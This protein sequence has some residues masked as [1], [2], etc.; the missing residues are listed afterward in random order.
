MK[1]EKG[2]TTARRIRNL[3]VQAL[4]LPFLILALIF[5]SAVSPSGASAAGPAKAG[6]IR[7]ADHPVCDCRPAQGLNLD[8]LFRETTGGGNGRLSVFPR[9]FF[10]L[11]VLD[12]LTLPYAE[13]CS[14]LRASEFLRCTHLFYSRSFRSRA[15]PLS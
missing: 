4:L 14:I 10:A 3:P 8:S 12:P 7:P 15:G 5:C 11:P 6:V 13:F 2:E 1:K 9:T